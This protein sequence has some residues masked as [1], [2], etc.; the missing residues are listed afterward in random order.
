[1]VGCPAGEAA[2]DHLRQAARRR[3]DMTGDGANGDAG[4]PLG[5]EAVTPVEI[6]G[7]AMDESRCAVASPSARR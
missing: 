3:G 2:K 7:N 1:M 4:G 6:A 5:R